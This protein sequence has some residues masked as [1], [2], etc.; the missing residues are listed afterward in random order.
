[1][2]A[3]SVS[4]IKSEDFCKSRINAARWASTSKVASGGMTYDSAGTISLNQLELPQHSQTLVVD[5]NLLLSLS[6]LDNQ[7]V[8]KVL[9]S[10]SF[11]Y[12]Y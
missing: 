10:Q 4:H 12:F 1:V 3:S 7:R 8:A 5:R 9:K 6:I 11:S 2:H